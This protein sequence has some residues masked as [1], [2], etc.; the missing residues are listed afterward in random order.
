MSNEPTPFTRGELLRRAA[1]TGAGLSFLGPASALAASDRSA[2]GGSITWAFTDGNS[3]DDLDPTHSISEAAVVLNG[4]LYESLLD[5]DE[6]WHPRPLL[7]VDWSSNANATRW[8]FRLRDGV[9]FHD[10]KPLTAADVV[11]SLQRSLNKATGSVIYSQ[12]STSMKA[13]GI[14]AL[15]KKTVQLSLLRPN[16]FLPSTLALRHAQIIPAGTTTQK[17]IG[18]GPF[19]LVSFTAA[20]GFEVKRSDSYW[21]KGQPFLDGVRGVYIADPSTKVQ[22][23]IQGQNQLTD[24]IDFALL[25]LIKKSNGV[26]VVSLKNN[27]YYSFG[28]DSRKKP[29]NDPRVVNA[30][31]HATDRKGIRQTVF[32]GYATVTNDVPMLPSDRFFPDSLPIRTYDPTKAKALLKKA[33]YPNGITFDLPTSNAGPDMVQLAVYAAEKWKAAGIKANIKQTPPDTYWTDVWEKKPTWVGWWANRS[34]YDSMSLAYV[35]N[36]GWNEGWYDNPKVVKLLNQAAATPN[37]KKQSAI[38]Q[39]IAVIVANGAPRVI[40]TF[41][42]SLYAASNGLSGVKLDLIRHIDFRTARLK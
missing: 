16:A 12:L 35:P 30:L 19:Q 2:A 37:E 40:P 1:V 21:I 31:Q 22:S 27:I 17:G 11:F 41:V 10:G 5:A 7:A 14:R 39:D 8:T 26:H 3:K 23:V 20:Q 33:G 24:S 15:D 13:S 34:A 28:F 36:S 9:E 32:Q 25:P 18:T 6:S 38:M 29:F 42:D 4:M